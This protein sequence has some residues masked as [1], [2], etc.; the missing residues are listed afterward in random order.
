MVKTR[1]FKDET[2]Y[3]S[4]KGNYASKLPDLY[5]SVQSILNR[6]MYSPK[7]MNYE[8]RKNYYNV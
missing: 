6:M 5:L 3:G 1:Y 7:R 8:G 4:G 2:G